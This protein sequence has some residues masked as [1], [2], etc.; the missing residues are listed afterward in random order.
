MSEVSSN[1]SV[2]HL[3][4]KVTQRKVSHSP[5]R[6]HSFAGTF[7]RDQQVE[8]SSSTRTRLVFWP[9]AG[10][11]RRRSSLNEYEVP[12]LSLYENSTTSNIIQ[13]SSQLFKFL[14]SSSPSPS[15]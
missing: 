2:V 6:P 13:D 12:R 3:R 8:E 4:K 11:A 7:N 14:R 5:P 15:G 10:L 9:H 1:T